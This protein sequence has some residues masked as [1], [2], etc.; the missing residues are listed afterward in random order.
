MKL[1]EQASRLLLVGGVAGLV[2]S[3]IIERAAAPSSCLAIPALA[4]YG[5]AFAV[6]LAQPAIERFFARRQPYVAPFALLACIGLVVAGV[7][8][9]LAAFAKLMLMLMNL[10]AV[11]FGT[12]VYL[13]LWGDFP[14]G[15]ARAVL[16]SALAL[17][18]VSGALVVLA[19]LRVVRNVRLVV[20][21]LFAL[22]LVAFVSLAH[23]FVPA[24]LASITDA[25]A[26]I[27][28]AIVGAVAA[29]RVGVSQIRPIR[30]LFDKVAG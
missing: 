1:S 10:L 7:F 29:L 12:A 19:D 3:A 28:V 6:R 27:V 22:L 15:D 30:G 9:A 26:A 24:I 2:L 16:A 13:V 25:I 21:Y 4:I 5:A 17:L 20:A 8:A 11:P 18:V 14:R 23:G